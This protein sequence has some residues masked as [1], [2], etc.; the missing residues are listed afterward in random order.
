[1]LEK[2]LV[3][4]VLLMSCLLGYAMFG[5]PGTIFGIIVLAFL[6]LKGIMRK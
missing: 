5:L 4:F 1:M 3:I 6:G 2:S